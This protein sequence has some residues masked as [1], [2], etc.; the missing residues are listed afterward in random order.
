[1]QMYLQHQP[2]TSYPKGDPFAPTDVGDEADTVY[3]E[4][5]HGLS[6]RLVV[7]ANGQS[8]LGGVQA[9]AMGEAWSDWYAMDYLVHQGL[10]RDGR[11]KADLVIFQYDGEGIFLDRTEPIDC[12]VGSQ[13]KLCTG[14]TTGHTGG[15]TY[16]DYGNIGGGPEVH[17][18]GE[19]WAQT[20]WDLRTKVG[21]KTADSLV[22]RAMELS[23][24]NP[25]YLDERNAILLADN[26]AFGGRHR[27]A[28]WSVFAHR[29]MGFF[30]GSLG[31]DDTQPGADF[32]TPPAGNKRGPISGTVTDQDS[33]EPIAGLNVSLAFQGAPGNANPATTTASDGTYSLGPVPV[34]TYP[35]LSVSGPGYDPAR[36]SVKVTQGGVV[37]NFSVRRDWAASSGGASI[38][39]F[40]GPDYGESCDPAAATDTSQATGW[41]TS[42]GAVPD[43]PSGTFVPH[44]VVIQ[45]PQ[46]IDVTQFAVDPA[47]ACGTGGSASTGQLRI[48]TSP[49]GTTWTT[50][51]TKEFTVDDRGVLTPVTPAAGTANVKFVRITPLS[52]QTPSFDTNCPDGAFGGCTYT[53]LTE[54]EVYGDGG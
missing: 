44:N 39:S 52:N 29:G 14:G 10:Q 22:T 4:Y 51:A 54:V 36:A 33:G 19:L 26:A 7:N 23:P 20:L 11:K 1:M 25:S 34:G 21:P 6:N 15:Y 40:T 32:H 38:K 53:S 27:N 45:L 28:I 50:A 48:E 43:E 35:K 41:V 30:A 16:A 18:D 5:T 49:D 31:G 12:K 46:A 3:H 9:G 37:K 24:S 42:T 47:S 13:A 8:T 2:G 17:S